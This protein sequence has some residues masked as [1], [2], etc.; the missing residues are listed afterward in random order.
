MRPHAHV[1]FIASIL[2]CLVQGG[3][4][5]CSRNFICALLASCN[6]WCAK[7]WLWCLSNP[8]RKSYSLRKMRTNAQMKE[9]GGGSR[10]FISIGDLCCVHVCL[11][12]LK[13]EH[14][15]TGLYYVFQ[16][17]HGNQVK[18][19]VIQI[20]QTSRLSMTKIWEITLSCKRSTWAATVCIYIC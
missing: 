12:Y 18:F 2:L 9:E 1:C 7:G 14:C 3:V 15:C 5:A 17:Q 10:F 16:S 19:H 6:H 11:Q 20:W 4:T 13:V 8:S